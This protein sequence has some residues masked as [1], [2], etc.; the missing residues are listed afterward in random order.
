MEHL[1]AHFGAIFCVFMKM[2]NLCTSFP[3][4]QKQ[5]YQ[6]KGLDQKLPT[7]TAI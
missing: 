1:Y 3:W 6:W 5:A 4:A 7:H 2:K